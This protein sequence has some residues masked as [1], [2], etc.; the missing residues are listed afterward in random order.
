VAGPG[1]GRHLLRLT[2]SQEWN[3][4]V[5]PLQAGVAVF[6][7]AAWVAGRPDRRG[8]RGLLTP[9]TGVFVDLMGRRT[10]L[11]VAWGSG[12]PVWSVRFDP[13]HLLPEE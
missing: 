5:G 12:G 9:G 13:G 1:F 4:G 10:M 6:A 2:L 7:D 3:R 8:A 11:S